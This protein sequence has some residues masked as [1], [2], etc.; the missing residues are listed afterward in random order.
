MTVGSSL[1]SKQTYSRITLRGVQKKWFTAVG[2]DNA[3]SLEPFWVF[4]WTKLTNYKEVGSRVA[5]VNV[6]S[7]CFIE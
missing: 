1:S 3:A 2:L 6:V 5:R 4:L 7:A